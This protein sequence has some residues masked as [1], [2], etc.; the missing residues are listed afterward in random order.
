MVT[1]IE[2]NKVLTKRNLILNLEKRCQSIQ[3]DID[4]FMLKYGILREKGLPSPL[5][6]H[7]KLM[8][9]EDYIERL[10]KQARSQA[11]SS[12]VKALPTG[13]V[14]YDGMENLFYIEHEVKHLFTSKPNFAKYTE[15]DE[16]YKKM[17]RMKLPDN[18]WWT[19]L[20]DIL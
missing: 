8:T 2:I 6:I 7:D 12:G 15:V 4:S 17:I 3:A 9:Q 10:N 19:S 14:L 5:V 20:T 11:G 13:K 1:I 16:V 18:E